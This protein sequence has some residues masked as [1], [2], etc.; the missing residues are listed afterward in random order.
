MPSG[1][2]RRS[3]PWVGAA[4]I[5]SVIGGGDWP[6][7]RAAE[8][9]QDK[10]S[11]S[12]LKEMKRHAEAITI[13]EES[14]GGP[15][16]AEL[17]ADPVARYDDQPRQIEDAT[18]WIWG[19]KGRPCAAL[20]VEVY[21]TTRLN[22]LVSMSPTTLAAESSLG[23]NWSSK[24][25]GVEMKPIPDAPAPAGTE[26]A[27][28][29]QMKDLAR[30]FGAYELDGPARGKVVL[31]LLPRQLH[32]YEDAASGL[33]DG[34]IFSLAYGTNPDILLLIEA[35]PASGGG[36]A[37]WQYGLARLGGGDLFA[38]LD[39]KEV[40]TAPWALPVPKSLETYMNRYIEKTPE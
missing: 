3:T 32:R 40:W 4:L 15:R 28:L 31:R 11:A 6:R 23:W 13:V 22:G 5:L 27:R 17:V 21:P 18:L 29:V 36:T 19:R 7:A 20:K 14:E 24:G 26:R 16:R 37:S 39:G 10:A 25:A 8:A 38:T 12:R 30:R 2:D 1:Q 35:R 9:A 34:A 33:Q